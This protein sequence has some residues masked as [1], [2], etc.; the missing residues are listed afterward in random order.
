MHRLWVGLAGGLLGLLLSLGQGPRGE[1]RH[2]LVG[3]LA[4]LA[5]LG[6]VGHLHQ[7]LWRELATKPVKE[8]GCYLVIRLVSRTHAGVG[9]GCGG[10]AGAGGDGGGWVW[11]RVIVVGSW[12]S[13]FL[14]SI[15]C[16][17]GGSLAVSCC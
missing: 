4:L 8:S 7:E 6:H 1:S 17:S 10:R 5:C 14:T 13:S 3:P 2:L 16:T 11:V 15:L 12:R 9:V